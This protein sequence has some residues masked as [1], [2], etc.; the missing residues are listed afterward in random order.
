MITQLYRST[1]LVLVVTILSA[2]GGGGHNPSPQEVTTLAA[3]E[4]TTD[5]ATLNLRVNP[6]GEITTAYFDWGGDPANA[7][8]SRPTI[9]SNG[10]FIAFA[11]D[12]TNLVPGD[13]NDVRDVFVVENP[14]IP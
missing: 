4:I 1:F 6:N 13:T 9:S 8:S 5:S 14:L 7:D 11:S 10:K 3:N 12:A 2:C